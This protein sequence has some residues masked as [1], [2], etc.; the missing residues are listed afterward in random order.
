LIVLTSTTKTSKSSRW[1]CYIISFFIIL[2]LL[3][4]VKGAFAIIFLTIIGIIIGILG[5]KTKKKT[6]MFIVQFIGVQ[7][8][9]CFFKDWEYL[10]VKF[11]SELNEKPKSSMNWKTTIENKEN[12]V[13][14]NLNQ[15]FGDLNNLIEKKKKNDDDGGNDVDLL[16]DTGI[17][18]ECL[19][20]KH[21]YVAM[22][23]F[24]IILGC[25]FISLFISY[26][27]FKL[28][29]KKNNLPKNKKLLPR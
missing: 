25:L 9:C 23:I 19:K 21:S 18:S 29:S 28:K 14:N 16:S 3:L 24:L 10:F 27:N 22:C 4:W 8:C 17:I 2:S 13:I 12:F 6:I 20:I 15:N 7:A 1:I 5:F 26:K 11:I